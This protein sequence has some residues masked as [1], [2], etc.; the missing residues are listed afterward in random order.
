MNELTIS[1]PARVFWLG[2]SLSRGARVRSAQLSLPLLT[3][4]L[5]WPLLTLIARQTV[6]F[7]GPAHSSYAIL[8]GAAR[9]SRIFLYL[10][11][12]IL[13]AFVAV[14]WPGIWIRLKQ[15][16]LLSGMLV[17]ALSSVLWTSSI[18]ITVQM[19]IEISLCTLFACY[20]SI[21]VSTR[22]L[23]Q[24]L[25]FM[26]V[27]ASLLSI[28]FALALPSYGIFAGYGTSAW[29]GICTH[30]NTL[31]VSSAYLLL[32]AFFATQ[33]SRSTRCAYGLLLVLLIFMSQSRGAWF[34][35][36]GVFVFVG[37]LHLYRQ[38]R[39]SHALLLVLI[40]GALCTVL[41][42][43]IAAYFSNLAALVGKDPTMSGRFKI[44]KEV[45]LAIVKRPIL[46]Y[47][48]GGFWFPG[49]LESQRLGLAIGWANIGYSESGIL[50]LALQIGSLGVAFLLA[51][52]ATAVIRA[53]KL[54]RSPFYTPRV[55]W[56]LTIL[57][58]AMLTNIDAGWFL[59]ADTL[60]WVLIV[61]ACIGLNEEWARVRAL[62]P[63]SRRN[64]RLRVRWKASR[65]L[66]Y[67]GDQ[68]A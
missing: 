67:V 53:V 18:K 5:F 2:P 12:A 26:G 8:Y 1:A 21:R 47:G 13:G 57:V 34:Y 42:V 24:I 20:L 30:K 56:F 51:M 25:M 41:I 44:Y 65:L 63:P 54:L 62:L 22:Q 49:S 16:L 52:I 6:Y 28:L 60:D 7:S 17:L 55:G 40:T 43:L 10:N 15:N 59:T 36:L 9:G 33:Y 58:L 39:R 68:H 45:W 64:T 38:M 11:Y 23:M 50:E 29:Q 4:L 61:I 32:P 35:T 19:F 66:V 14:G 37:W 27:V 31:G 48:L 46:G 3:A